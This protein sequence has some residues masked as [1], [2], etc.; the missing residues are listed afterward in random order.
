MGNVNFEIKNEFMR[1]LREETFSGNKNDD[2]H[3]HIE[4]VLDIVILFN[5]PG[6]TRD[7]VMLRVFLITLIEAPKRWV[8]KLTPGT[9]STWELLKKAFIQRYCPSSKTAKQLEDIHNFKQEGEDTLYQAWERCQ[10]CNG[11]YLGKECPLNEDAKSVEEDDDDLSSEG[12]PCQLPPKEINLGSFTL[13]CTIGSLDFYAMTELGASISIMP[14]SMFKETNML[15]EMADMTKK[16]MILGRPF[17][18]TIHAEINVLNEEISLGIG[19]DM[20]IFNMNKKC[21]KFTTPVGKAYMVNFVHSKD[22]IDIDCDLFLYEFESYEFNRH[23][24]IDPDIFTCDIDIQESYEEIVYRYGKVYKIIWDKILKDHWKERFGEE[25]DDTDEGWEDPEKCG[26]EKIDVILNTVLD[27]LH[28][29]WFGET[30]QDEDDLE[31]ITDYLELTSYDGFIDHE[32]EAYK[33]RSC[34]F[35]GMPYVR[36]PPIL[37]EKVKS[38]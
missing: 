5:I 35:L 23:L 15:V 10:L 31:G 13:P 27:K 29:S 26:E 12:L 28:D 30:T 2:A 18:A 19:N 34:N 6:V 14:K 1:E 16:T 17:L 24:A 4:R 20:I 9:I 3:E 22:L 21:Y 8:D 7:A 32:D 33:E 11:P 38:Y 36:P 25:D 37:I